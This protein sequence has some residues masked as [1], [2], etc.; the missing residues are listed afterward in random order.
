MEL[1]NCSIG[2]MYN[3]KTV[4]HL[5]YADD[6]VLLSPSA[7][8]LQRLLMKCEDY[9]DMHDIKF[10]VTKT[11]CMCIKPRWMKKQNIPKVSLHGTELKYVDYYKYLGNI[12]SEEYRDD[13]D[14]SCKIRKLYCRGNSLIRNFKFCS[15]DVKCM[16]FKTYFSSIYGCSMW[17]SY[18]K[19]SLNC[20]KVAH[21]SIFRKLLGLKR[22]ASISSEMATCNVN[23]FKVIH[24]IHIM[25]FTSVQAV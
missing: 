16:L 2:C 5:F 21:N 6:S 1:K 24:R 20:V 10:N 9:S 15:T 22:D 12:I 8:G 25:H 3:D 23:H 13:T 11:V 14:I 4:N 18:T 7:E 19:K 17:T